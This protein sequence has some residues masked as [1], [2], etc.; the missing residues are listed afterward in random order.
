MVLAVDSLAGC[1]VFDR[2]GVG[3]VELAVACERFAERRH[4]IECARVFGPERAAGDVECFAQDRLGLRV[5]LLV[6]Q[7]GAQAQHGA[8]RV[9]MLG[10]E[11]LLLG[12]KDPGQDL[13]G[14]RVLPLAAERLAG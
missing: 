5:L 6:T 1:K 9:G 14:L 8:E 12:R 4:G 7:V 11:G 13:A 3:L 2:E 10:A